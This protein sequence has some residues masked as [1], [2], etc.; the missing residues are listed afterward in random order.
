M[1]QAGGVMLASFAT[2][3]AEF[4]ITYGLMFGV[5]CGIAYTCPLVCGLKWMPEKKGLV[6]GIVTVRNV[7]FCSLEDTDG[8]PPP[9]D[10]VRSTP[11]VSSQGPHFTMEIMLTCAIMMPR[12]NEGRVW[13]W[14]FCIQLYHHCKF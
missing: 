7:E 11:A 6:N 3:L 8:C 5:G 9:H 4:V 10:G 13:T 1:I 12:N 2:T 14:C